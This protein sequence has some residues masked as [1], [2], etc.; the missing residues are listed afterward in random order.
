VADVGR[1]L[2]CVLVGT[3][4]SMVATFVLAELAAD[5]GRGVQSAVVPHGT[6]WLVEAS[7]ALAVMLTPRVAIRVAA[8]ARSSAVVVAGPEAKRTLLY[9]ADWVGVMMARAASRQ[10]DA[11]LAPVGFLDEDARLRGRRVAGIRVFGGVESLERASRKTGATALLIA[12]PNVTG[13][14]VRR[15]AHAAMSLGMEVRTV[16]PLTGLQDGTPDLTRTR[17]LRVEDFLRR[18]PSQD[19]TPRVQEAIAGKVVVITGAGGSVGSELARQALAIG[20]SR[21]ALIDIAES[22]LYLIDRELRDQLAEERSLEQDAANAISSH[23]LDVTD[24]P[25]V[26]RLFAELRPDVVL[27]AAAYKHVSMLEDHPAKAVEVNIGG[28][29]SVV[30]AAAAVGAQRFVLVSTDQAARPSTTAGASM[31]V[32]EMIVADVG[33]RLGRAYVSVRFGNVLGSSGSVLPIFRQQLKRGRALTL[34]DPETTRSFVTASEAARLVLDAAALAQEPAQYLLEMSDPLRVADIATDLIR[35]AGQD[36]GSIPFKVVGLRKGEELH[37]QASIDEASARSTE[38]P[39]VLR[40]APPITTP[41]F[42]DELESLLSADATDEEGL[43]SM[44]S[45]FVTRLSQEALATDGRGPMTQGDVVAIP[46]HDERRPLAAVAIDPARSPLE[47]DHAEIAASSGASGTVNQAMPEHD[48]GRLSGIVS[49]AAMSE[50]DERI[51]R[52]AD[53]ALSGLG[54]A[55]LAPTM[56]AI[57]VLVRRTSPGPAFYR[58][59]R[60]GRNGAEFDV[61]KFRS[62]RE[63]PD[64]SGPHF[65]S[66]DDPRITPFGRAL[67]RFKL[68]ELPQLWNVLKGDMSLVGPRPDVRGYMDRLR[69]REAGLLTLRPGITGPATLYLRDEERLFLDVDDRQGHYDRVLWPHKVRINLDYVESWSLKRDI[70]YLAVTALP[71]LDRALKV[72]PDQDKV[73]RLEQAHGSIAWWPRD[74][75]PPTATSP[76]PDQGPDLRQ[77]AHTSANGRHSNGTAPRPAGLETSRTTQGERRHPAAHRRDRDRDPIAA[78]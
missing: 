8:G 46:V 4:V 14:D 25:A 12:T 17:R 10:H 9:G 68:D 43:R 57:A 55:V 54:L 20:A 48:A 58:H 56:G 78:S 28:T 34:T 76:T 59:R 72:I 13:D 69:G 60:V 47:T 40:T 15:I 16:R 24:R 51:K 53:I 74:A 37:A 67:R 22:P 33:R 19:H 41:S 63:M 11:D 27:H 38:I 75:M 3:I 23:L 61:M 29:L 62:M 6:F 66:A 49:M 31:H 2:A 71:P 65:T 26:T 35:L 42:R 77:A 5:A 18:T 36:P 70:A 39:R 1:A 21:I 73:A 44:L 30:D 52:L 32:A 45:G 64:W 7:L 50:R